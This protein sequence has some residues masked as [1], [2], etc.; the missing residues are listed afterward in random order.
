MSDKVPSGIDAYRLTGKRAI[1]C[2]STQGIGK[3]CAL[4]FARLG[5]AVTLAARD[6]AALRRV[7]AELPPDEGQAHSFI[8][9]D[10][11]EPQGVAE[12]VTK[13]LAATGP[14]HIL[15]NNSGGPPHGPI[16]AAT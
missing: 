13:H 12:K 3:A 10:F 5:A 4:Q 2:G 14:V 15:L 8:C 1:V 11:N 16:T 7:V 6:E 9:A